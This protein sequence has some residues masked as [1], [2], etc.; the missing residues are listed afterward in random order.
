MTV[1]NSVKSSYQLSPPG[2]GVPVAGMM[3]GS[4]PSTSIVMYT[5]WPSDSRT[6]IIQLA[7]FRMLTS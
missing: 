6:L 3:A 5:V 7:S 2:S 4:I 1:R